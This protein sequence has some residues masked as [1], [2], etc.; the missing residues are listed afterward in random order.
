MELVQGC[1][2]DLQSGNIGQGTVGVV[3]AVGSPRD[4]VD[5]VVGC[6]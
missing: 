3:F 1:G 2:V 6:R 4:W 5:G